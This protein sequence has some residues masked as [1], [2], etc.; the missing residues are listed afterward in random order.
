MEYVVLVDEQDKEIGTMEKLQA[1]EEGR[2]HRAISVF[3][4][5][6]NG[7]MLLQ[8]RAAGKYHSALL[9]TNA[10]CSHPRPGESVAD[11][12]HRRLREEMGVGS[13]LQEIFNF[14]YKAQLEN[15]LTEHEFDH[16][17][18]GITDK[19]PQPDASEVAAFRYVDMETLTHDI[20]ANPDMYT[21]WFKICI[22]E[23]VARLQPRN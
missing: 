5:N 9:W 19:E 16:V 23:H 22:K 3:I 18:K 14:T 1:H 2:L 4:F 20:A 12:A 17:F 8:Q 21:E 10:C 6:T 15:N 11:A 13:P 7:D